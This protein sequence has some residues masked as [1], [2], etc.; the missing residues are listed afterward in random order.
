MSLAD[1][2]A[3]IIDRGTKGPSLADMSCTH[4]MYTILYCRYKT[5]NVRVIVHVRCLVVYLDDWIDEVRH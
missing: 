3:A 5:H 1:E 4:V 2:A